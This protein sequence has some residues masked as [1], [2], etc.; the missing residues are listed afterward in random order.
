MQGYPEHW[1]RK[2]SEES[3]EDKERRKKKAFFKARLAITSLSCQVSLKN[4]TGVTC[5]CIFSCTYQSMQSHPIITP[6]L[7]FVS[8]HTSATLFVSPQ[9]AIWINLGPLFLSDPCQW[10]L[11]YVQNIIFCCSSES[12]QHICPYLHQEESELVARTSARHS[13]YRC[14]DDKEKNQIIRKWNQI[15]NNDNKIKLLD[16]ILA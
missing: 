15:R 12:L 2:I 7:L 14:D 16:L 10:V 9:K 11:W 1:I 6:N 5:L 13:D 4:A 3:V 8:H